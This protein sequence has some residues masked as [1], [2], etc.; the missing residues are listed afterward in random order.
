VSE[1]TRRIAAPA[2]AA[3]AALALLVAVVVG[4]ANDALFDSGDFSERAVA[5]LQDDAV[6]T[7]VADRV[8]DDLVLRAEADLVGFRPLIEGV[9]DGIVGG[10]V[11]QS[12]FQA[13]VADLHRAVFEQDANTATLTLADLGQVLRGAFEAL[14]PQIAK[15]I[16]GAADFEVAEID[17]PDWVADL[18]R[19]ADD[20]FWAEVILLGLAL[21]LIVAA[22]AVDRDR[23]RTMA[24]LGLT[25]MIFGALAVV[26]LGAAKAFVLTRV[27]PGGARDALDGI[28]RAFLGDL[29]TTL[30]LFAAC[31]AV[32]A[33]A[34]SSL[35]R[36]VDIAAPL[37]AGFEF[38][39][40]VPE[41][42]WLRALRALALIAAGIL[43]I[44]RRDAF[45][46]LVVISAGLYVAYAGVGELMRMVLPAEPAEAAR[47]RATGAR[48]LIATAVAAGVIVLAGSLFVGVGGTDEAPAA[49]QTE[50][51]NG[52]DQLCDRRLDE[53]AFPATHNAMSA[54]TNPGWL[55]AQ[56]EKG[57][58]DQL[59]DGIRAL[60]IDAHY[61]TPTEG[62][63][64]KTDLSDL[65]GSEREAYEEEL[66]PEA[67]DAALRIRDRLVD[68][69]ETGPRQVYLCHRFCELGA[70]PIDQ[71][72]RQYRDFLAANPDEVLVLD[73]ED[74]VDP[75]DIDEA[76]TE[77]GLIDYVYDGPLEPLPTLQ[78]VIDSGGRA[79]MVAE[80]RDGGEAIPYYHSA[81]DEL[82]QETPYSFKKPQLLT[83]TAQ[84]E[85][86]CEPNRG[87][88]AAPLFLINH[89]IDTSPAPKPSNAAKVNAHDPLLA[90]LRTCKE[91]RG[92]TPNLI[93]VDFY[94]EGDLFDVA[95]E[96]N[97]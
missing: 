69:K 80:N 63:T 81:Y 60:L 13:G 1:G 2:L 15:Q 12:A 64:I 93:A 73:I 54:A 22:L 29:T 41:R 39:A 62:G 55:F 72:F 18:A 97:R 48:A 67:L 51:C 14:R 61:G 88:E 56:Q 28:W 26:G 52:G 11:F 87:P 46:D 91:Q 53:V 79:I 44:L 92:L 90:R 4:Y 24:I 19:I 17:A 5:A 42:P 74:Y 10:S 94:R 59:A 21:G 34:A 85:A 76:V 65:K 45:L 38:I 35:L 58:P 49:I 43:I 83:D 66:G 7:E 40:R 89:W 75:K 30:Y 50:G 57:F 25:V 71:A 16:P 84:H 9:V 70:I 95:E 37:R 31:G 3:L 78:Q 96:L 33:A 68:S 77:S 32:V 82:V 20:A 27:D 47:E 86:S 36:P 23:R 6:R 8:T